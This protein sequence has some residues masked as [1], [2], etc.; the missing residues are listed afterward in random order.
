[1]TKTAADYR[2]EFVQLATYGATGTKV[3][4][5][6]AYEYHADQKAFVYVG[7]FTAP[8]KTANKNLWKVVAERE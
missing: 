4:T 5:F 6:K 7:A 1:M 2:I 3:K 8:A